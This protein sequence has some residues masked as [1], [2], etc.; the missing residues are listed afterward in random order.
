MQDA[1]D[2]SLL[3]NLY[4]YD[5]RRLG[6]GLE[7]KNNLKWSSFDSGG[8]YYFNPGHFSVQEEDMYMLNATISWKFK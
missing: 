3:Y 4:C 2:P 1:K 7:D 6:H 5:K 8:K